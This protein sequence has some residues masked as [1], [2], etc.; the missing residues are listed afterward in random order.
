M[1]VQANPKNM[2]ENKVFLKKT[3][4]TS[5]RD[6]EEIQLYKAKQCFI[7]RFFPKILQ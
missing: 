2:F 7:S 1:K 5:I 6:K 3:A 4:V